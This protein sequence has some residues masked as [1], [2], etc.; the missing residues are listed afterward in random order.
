M[1]IHGYNI[2]PDYSSLYASSQNVKPAKETTAASGGDDIGET[3]NKANEQLGMVAGVANTINNVA[4]AYEE[5][6]RGP[7]TGANVGETTTD[8]VSTGSNI[9]DKVTTRKV[10][11]TETPTVQQPSQQIPKVEDKLNNTQIQQLQKQITK[12]ANQ[13]D[14]NYKQEEEQ[15]TQVSDMV[16]TGNQNITVTKNGNTANVKE[17]ALQLGK[18]IYTPR[19]LGDV[20]LDWWTARNVALPV[21]N[22]AAQYNQLDSTNRWLQAGMTTQ[23]IMQ[24]FAAKDR[25]SGLYNPTVLDNYYISN[26]VQLADLA[27]NWNDRNAW[28]NAMAG[29]QSAVDMIKNFGWADALGGK[30][31]LGQMADGLAYLN[32]GSSIYQMGKNWSSMNAE[33]KTAAFVQTLYAGVQA[34]N[35]GSLLINTFSKSADVAT[36]TAAQSLTTSTATQGAVEGGTE[37]ATQGAV[38]GGAVGE[39]TISTIGGGFT[40]VIGAY[41]MVKGIEGLHKSFGVGSADSRKAGALAGTEAGI[42]AAGLGVGTAVL[43]GASVGSALPVIGTV[44]GAAVGA[45]VGVATG[46]AKTGHSKE[47]RARDNWRRTYTQVGVFSKAPKTEGSSHNTYAMQ[48]ADGRWY[49]VGHDGSGSRATF[50]NGEVKQIANPDRLTEADKHRMVND[51]TGAVRAVL[52]YNVDYTNDLDLLGSMMLAGM[53]V[54]VGGSYQNERSAEVPQMIGYMTNGITSNCGRDFSIKNYQIMADNAKALY[55]KIGITNKDQMVNSM[56]EAYLMGQL[57]YDD[58]MSSLTAANLMYDENGYQQAQAMIAGAQ[59]EPQVPSNN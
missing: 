33:E 27:Y 40:A 50:I 35:G 14:L 36:P 18:D 43:M 6:Q 17:N 56:G 19:D 21:L 46:S 47:Q 37:A 38:E 44:I 39:S 24:N 10:V 5:W 57:T 11:P 41:G 9:S 3:K 49:D 7:R 48:L 53:I 8:G 34:Y 28:Q 2:G 29:A 52:P 31:T 15:P 22:Y 55:A 20:S 51:K 12:Q 26:F 1:A 16:Q 25:E 4:N 42:G 30:E 54:P 32:F 13:N 45:V 59:Q 23:R 58:Y